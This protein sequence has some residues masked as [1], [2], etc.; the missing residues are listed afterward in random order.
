MM[1]AMVRVPSLTFL[2]G[3]ASGVEEL[4]VLRGEGTSDT[5]GVAHLQFR[6]RPVLDVI[7]SGSESHVHLAVKVVGHVYRVN[8][9]DRRSSEL[10]HEAS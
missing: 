8:R 10:R 2:L 1:R 4:D 6:K 3:P 5:G 7:H 9:I